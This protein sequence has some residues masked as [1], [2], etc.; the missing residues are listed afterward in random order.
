M[1]LHAQVDIG[2]RMASLR[3]P[4][5]TRFEVTERSMCSGT[6]TGGLGM[7]T[8]CLSGR[9]AR[10]VRAAACVLA[11]SCR[12]TARPNARPGR[13]RQHRPQNDCRCCRATWCRRRQ[14]AQMNMGPGTH[15][16]NACTSACR[17]RAA[18]RTAS[19]AL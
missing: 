5:Y 16:R 8:A 19:S 12:A 11:P 13:R 17:A 2:G 3:R 6:G 10:A 9:R 15:D 7:R 14:P 1:K 4:A 18:V